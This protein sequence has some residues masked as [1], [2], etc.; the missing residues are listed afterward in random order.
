MGLKHPDPTNATVKDLYANAYRCA[1][2]SCK[3]PLYRVDGETGVR[4]P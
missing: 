1:A 3:R 4:T 2:P